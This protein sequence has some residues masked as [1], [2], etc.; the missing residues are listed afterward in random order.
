LKASATSVAPTLDDPW[1][2]TIVLAQTPN[3]A[4]HWQAFHLSDLRN[5]GWPESINLWKNMKQMI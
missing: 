3:G 4:L 5:L 2:M 1:M